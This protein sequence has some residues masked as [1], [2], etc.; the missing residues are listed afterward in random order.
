MSRFSTDVATAVS[1]RYLKSGGMSRMAL[2]VSRLMS[3]I[4]TEDK[5]VNQ[6]T[7]A[8]N[9]TP[10]ASLVQALPTIAQ[11][12]S[13]STRIGDSVL[14]NRID[15]ELEFQYSGTAATAT[16][17]D[18][19]FRFWLIRYKKTPPTGG[20]TPFNIS[21]FL[22][23]DSNGNYSVQSFMNT[24]TNENFQ[25]MHTQDVYLKLPT[26]ASATL[27]VNKNIPIRHLPHFHQAYNGPTAASITDNMM[28]FVC[29]SLTP[30]NTGGASVVSTAFRVWFVD[31]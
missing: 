29:V 21:E 18:Q 14:I 5:Q 2:D 23:L 31:N 20:I 7:G 24:D 28:F 19:T 16:S 22:D 8:S 9:V 30:A 25:I 6:L 3:L 27:F 26:L 12:T 11:G 17:T 4:N 1:N 13:A 10:A 15:L